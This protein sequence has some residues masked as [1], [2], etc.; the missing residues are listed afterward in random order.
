MIDDES[1]LPAPKRV[2]PPEVEPVTLGG[3]R[4][5]AVHW[6]RERG[7]GQNGGYIEAFDA[8]TGAALWLLR[9][10]AIDYRDEL[11]EDVQDLFIEELKAGPRGK[12]TVIDEQG[13]RFTVDPA[14]RGVTPR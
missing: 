4:F 3:L 14:T 12:L 1:G 6:G 7:L 10:Y 13:R 11:E 9:I 5:E 2:G 8:A